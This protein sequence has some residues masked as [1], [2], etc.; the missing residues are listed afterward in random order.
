MSAAWQTASAVLLSL[1]GGGAVVLFLSSW[2]G[3]LWANRLMRIE[4]AKHDERLR[5]LEAKLKQQVSDFEMRLKTE[6][7]L[8]FDVTRQKI[9]VYRRITSP[10]LDLVVEAQHSQAMTGDTL[11][12]FERERLDGT[13]QLAMLAPADVFDEYNALIDYLWDVTES[14]K[15]WNFQE[16]RDKGLVFLSMVRKDIGLHSDSVRYTG[17]R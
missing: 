4:S 9:E 12:A 2:L 11:L 3:K 17:E 6:L 8:K 7:D 1:S 13:A 16:F 5:E 14:K 10:I 15:P